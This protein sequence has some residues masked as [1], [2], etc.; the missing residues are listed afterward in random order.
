MI[1]A[2]VRHMPIDDADES[3]FLRDQLRK[4]KEENAALVSAGLEV[5]KSARIE[6]ISAGGYTQHDVSPL[7]E[8][9]IKYGHLKERLIEG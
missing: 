8:V 7:R 5:L 1:I 9:L 3:S 2:G 4:L 6:A